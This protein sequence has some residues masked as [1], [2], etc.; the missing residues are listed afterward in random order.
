ME[1][2]PL[3]GFRMGEMVEE[4]EKKNWCDKKGGWVTTLSSLSLVII[5]MIYILFE[6]GP[7]FLEISLNLKEIII[8]MIYILFEN[9][10]WFSEV[11]LNLKDQN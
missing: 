1:G 8:I 6:N 2:W 4:R 5:I 10:L 7:W 3:Q 11:A 9:D